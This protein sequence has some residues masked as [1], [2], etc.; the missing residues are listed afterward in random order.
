MQRKAGLF[1]VLIS[2]FQLL[3]AQE[4]SLSKETVKFEASYA[5]DVYANAAGGLK[6]GGGYMG[7]G[8][9][10]IAFD[11]GKASWWKGGS[12]FINGASIHGK[13]LSG[14]FSGDLQIA[15]N[16]DAGTH[17]YLHELWF[18][19]EFKKISFTIGLQDA[20][21]EFM[22]SENGAEFINSSFGVPP[23]VSCNVPVPIFP[24]TGLGIS[25]KWNIND[26][27]TWQTAVFDGNQ[28][29]FEN[30]PYNLNWRLSKDDGLFLVTEFHI[31]TKPNKPNGIYKLGYFYHSG[32]N[33]FDKKTRTTNNIFRNNYGFYLIADQ[34]VFERDNRKIGLFIQ[35]AAAPK[36][37]NEHA[38]Y[39]GLGAN[40][41]GI[42]SKK[43]KDILGLAVAHVDLQKTK[44]K[45]ETTLELYYKWQFNEN[46][47]I[48]PDI[49]YIINPSGTSEKLTNALLG[50]LRLYVDF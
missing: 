48:Q 24:L 7:M 26:I 30:N 34:M 50:I 20:N 2:V 28:G 41:Y 9:L 4:E 31:N 39:L 29:S 47:A 21:A 32:I 35:V 5:G 46:F 49:Q 25:A 1:I 18:K 8:N 27:F 33:E 38:Y 19:Q 37:K 3:H 11:T 6:T 43:G 44:H 16:I 42:F 15:S 12:F 36:S 40:Y 45:H 17:A 23:V 10:K 14:N 13:S 22:V